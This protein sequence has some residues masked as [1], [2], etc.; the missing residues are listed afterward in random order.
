MASSPAPDTTDIPWLLLQ[1]ATHV[2]AGAFAP[3]TFI[4]RLSTEKGPAP[5]TGCDAAHVG[6]EVL[7]PYAADYFFY[8]PSSAGE[9]IRQCA[10][11]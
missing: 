5:A 8:R 10:T 4:Q 7:V 3:V 6:T 9:R 2:G 11:R 1:A